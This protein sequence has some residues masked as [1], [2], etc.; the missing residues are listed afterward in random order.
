MSPPV[1]NCS[2]KAVGASGGADCAHEV[3][4]DLASYLT[5]ECKH[6]NA[7]INGDEILGVLL[8]PTAANSPSSTLSSTIGSIGSLNATRHSDNRH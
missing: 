1:A 8:A 2:P 7:R 5:A 4:F 6:Y 3:P